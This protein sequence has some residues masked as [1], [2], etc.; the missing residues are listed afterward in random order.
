MICVAAL[1]ACKSEHYF[2]SRSRPGVA[3]PGPKADGSVLLPNQWSLRP[4]GRQ[5]EVGDFPVNLA[6]HP[7]GKFAAMLHSGYGQHE[8]IV[9]EIPSGKITAREELK[10]SFYGLEFSSD[11]R[12]LVSSGA[13]EEVIHL[14]RFKDGKL[15]DHRKFPLRN[16]DERGVPAGIALDRAAKKLF[17]AN[18]LG[19]RVTELFLSGKRPPTDIVL[20]Q[21]VSRMD[22]PR[23]KPSADAETFA[24]DKRVQAE[25]T[26]D[27]NAIDP[28]PYACRIDEKRQRLYVSLWAHAEVVVIDLKNNSII[29]HWP[30]EE[31]PCEMVLSKSGKFL[32][33]A[34]SARNTVTVIDTDKGETIETIWAAL[35]PEIPPGSTPNSL[36]LSPDDDLLFI[37]NADNNMVAAIDVSDP[38]RSRSLGFIPVGWYPTSVRVTPNGRYL[39]VTNGKGLISHANPGGPNPAK[40]AESLDQYITRMFKGTLSVIELPPRKELEEQMKIYTAQ[41]YSC[42]PLRNGSQT[43]TNRTANNPIPLKIGEPSPIKYCIYVI[44][45][46]RTYDQIL[47][48]MPQGN[49]DPKICLFPEKV[50][51]NHHQLARDFVLLDNFYVESE[52]SADGH[53]WSMGAYATDFVEKFWPLTYGHNKQGKYAF[54]AEGNFQIAAPAGGYLWD[55]A[56]E[57]GVS[58]RSYGEFVGYGRDGRL[59]AKR[60]SLVGHIDPNFPPFDLNF[61]DLKRA[62]LF[63]HELRR[64]ESEGDMPRLQIVR[65]PNDHTHGGTPDKLTPTSYI[66]ENDLAFGQIVEA[67]SRSK[68]WSETAIFVVEDDAQNGPDHVDAHRTIAYAISP[69]IKRG[70]VDSTMYST[71][72]MLRTMELI[73]G[74]K[75]MSQFDAAAMPMYKS[76]QGTPDLRPYKAVPAQV[77]LTER[78]AAHGR[79]AKLS[80]NMDFREEDEVDD[81]LLNRVIWELVR[82]AD[83]PM[84]APTRAAFVFAH[85]DGGDD[86]D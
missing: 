77:S 81:L 75:P 65:L 73:L 80:Q 9:V 2:K 6:V 44:K 62:E 63:K 71:S 25:L 8:I 47:G 78:N 46:N 30:S 83:E 10:E 52:V 23:L 3:L 39:L 34:N 45:E 76:F 64:F 1:V 41:A 72:S 79:P 15:S 40:R 31:H 13:G 84:P 14:F 12:S 33:V 38:G 43:F 70:S 28:F 67:V 5:I 60:R 7:S 51:P 49:G 58:V 29:N 19:Q 11:G 57:A 53:E 48:D 24:A 37:A 61:S 17:V 16:A 35:Y 50:T 59:H 54:P 68:F 42:S 20:E 69:Y 4:A 55:R 18:V 36:A 26:A 56:L 82:G 85:Q 74:L 21:G 66:A 86:D 22:A 32:Y 27:K